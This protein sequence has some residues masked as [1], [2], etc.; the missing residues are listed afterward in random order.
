M[1]RIAIYLDRPTVAAAQADA[2]IADAT[3]SVIAILSQIERRQG[4]D[5]RA[6]L[7]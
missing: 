4:R 1:I 7:R 2:A 6:I 5:G 3:R